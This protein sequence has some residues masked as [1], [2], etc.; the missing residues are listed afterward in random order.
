[1]VVASRRPLIDYFT[2][3]SRSGSMTSTF[4]SYFVPYELELFDEA[5]AD[6]LLLQPSD[7]TLTLSEVAAAKGWAG[8]H[9]CHL[10]CAGAGLYEA[11]AAGKP[12]AWGQKRFADIKRQACD[13]GRIP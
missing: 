3:P 2:D 10:Q 9:P 6:A 4:P 8:G 13:V 7:Q 11:R 1:M 5:A 12:I